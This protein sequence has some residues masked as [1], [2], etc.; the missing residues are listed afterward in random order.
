MMCAKGYRNTLG[1]LGVTVVP[2]QTDFSQRYVPTVHQLEDEERRGGPIA[3][4]IVANPGNPTG[5][6]ISPE[7]ILQLASFCSS[8]RAAFVVDEI[9]NC[10]SSTTIP[11]ALEVAPESAI[12]ISSFSKVCG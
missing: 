3:G 6:S 8:R 12:V 7:E 9:Y 11:S 4:L 5:C 10:V 2:V 1:A